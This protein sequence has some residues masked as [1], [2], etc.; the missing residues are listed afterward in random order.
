M[1]AHSVLAVYRASETRLAMNATEGAICT[2]VAH[3]A[4]CR[5]P[6]VLR[7]GAVDPSSSLQV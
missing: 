7:I 1:C 3:A 6:K 2:D 4:G 5:Q